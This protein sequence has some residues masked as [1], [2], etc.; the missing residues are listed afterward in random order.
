VV[1]I[2]SAESFLLKYLRGNSLRELVYDGADYFEMGKFFGT[3]MLSVIANKIPQ[4]LKPQELR[5]YSLMC[6]IALLPL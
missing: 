5:A 6:F 4:P 2:V 1:G 3:S